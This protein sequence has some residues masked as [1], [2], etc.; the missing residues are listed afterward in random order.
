MIRAAQ[1][2]TE[3]PAMARGLVR[4]AAECYARARRG[5]AVPDHSYRSK[6]NRTKRREHGYGRARATHS[7]ISPRAPTA[8]TMYCLPW[9]R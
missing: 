1:S 7:G 8:T 3:G 5:I 4:E 6:R 2:Q 9:C